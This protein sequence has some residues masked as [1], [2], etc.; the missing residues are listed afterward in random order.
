V[1]HLFLIVF[2]AASCASVPPPRRD[3]GAG[4]RWSPTGP[5]YNPG[6]DYWSGVGSEMASRFNAVPE[7]VWIVTRKRD[8]GT[9]LNFPATARD[10]LVAT[11]LEDAN[12]AALNEFDRLGFRVWLQIEPRHA[13]VEEL[14]HLV[15]GRYCHHPSVIGIGVDVEWYLSTNPDAGEAVTDA[16]AAAWLTAARRHNKQYRLF[17]KHWLIVKMPPTMRDGLL[18]IDDS[19]IFPNLEAMVDEFAA[20]GRAFAPAP[21]GYQFGYP[22]DRH[23]WSKLEDPPREIGQAILAR[24]PNT[25][26][27]YWVDFT[28][29]DIFPPARTPIAE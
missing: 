9:I 23:W 13:D 27:L 1:K 8:D 24:V 20:W 7:T 21:V 22:S 17:L 18:F 6:H 5:K 15:L 25:T 10:P 28:V 11:S 16:V 29:N 2:F 4:F 26:G 14:I 19:Q 3:L 12:E